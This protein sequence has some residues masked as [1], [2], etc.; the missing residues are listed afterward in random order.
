MAH[1]STPSN[2][3]QNGARR[4]RCHSGVKLLPR[5]STLIYLRQFAR[6]YNPGKLLPP[7]LRTV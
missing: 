1:I 3:D 4:S 6:I 7:T 5:R 2:D